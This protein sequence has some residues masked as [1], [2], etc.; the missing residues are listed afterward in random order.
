[1]CA[2]GHAHM[3]DT[4]PSHSYAQIDTPGDMPMTGPLSAPVTAALTQIAG[5]VLTRNNMVQLLTDGTQSYSAMFDLISEAKSEILFENFIFRADH[6]G[7]AFAAAL[8]DRARDG[9]AVRVLYDPF[10]SLMTLRRPVGRVFRGS[11]VDVRL[12]NPP[13]PTKAFLR[14]GRDHRKIVVQD[15]ER[16]VAGG[17][18]IADVWAGNC[19]TQCTWRDAAIL[20]E[21]EAA[22]DAA[23]EFTDMWQR[24]GSTGPVRAPSA[25]TL[26]RSRNRGVG[27]VPVRVLG[28]MPGERRTERALIT[29]F[30]AAR[31]EILISNSYFLPTNQLVSALVAARARGVAVSILTPRYTNH[32]VVGMASHHALGALLHAGVRVWRWRGPM[33]HAKTVVVDHMWSLIGST[34]LDA[35]SLYRNAELNVEVHG[36]NTGQQM[37]QIFQR[38]CA[39][40]SEYQY[41]EWQARSVW[42]KTTARAAF[43]L[44]NWL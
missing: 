24:T 31:S 14:L 27:T 21:G 38:D 5:R 15:R 16:F 4:Q 23:E 10:G 18:C 26:M 34:N 12:Y 40:S 7:R 29:V 8:L 37:A 30:N 11:A 3:C 35:L 1:M 28:D 42:R 22:A 25:G 41:A 6:A 44:K 33:M 19:V 36:S 2:P 43:T 9:M 13:R 32:H 20:V 17:L 39:Q